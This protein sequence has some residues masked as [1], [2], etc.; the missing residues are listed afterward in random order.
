MRNRY[1]ESAKSS[2]AYGPFMSN[3][4]PTAGSGRTPPIALITGATAG[5]GAAFARRLAQEGNR[6]VLVARDARRLDETA[7]ELTERYQVP[8]ETLPAD[9]ADPDGCA[10]V[11]QRVAEPVDLLVNNAGMG[12]QGEFWPQPVDRVEAMLALNMRAVMRLAHAA[13]GPMVTRGRGDVINISSVAGFVPS[14]RTATYG[15]SKAWVTS[16]SEALSL[17]LLGSGV[18][19]SALCPGFTHTEFHDRAH[20]DMDKLPEWLWLN[21][22]DVVAT[23][24]RDHRAGRSVSVPGM[25]Y[26]AIVTAVKL[27]P[28]AV[29]RQATKQSRKVIG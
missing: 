12:G 11:E 13:L 3:T 8:V 27:T 23:G 28:R 7:A 1:G 2:M 20:I 10:L 15:A 19:V 29:L 17:E 21:A 24:L 4:G 5:I 22:D 25:Q 16:F 14:G 9:L 26:K 18:H 6:L